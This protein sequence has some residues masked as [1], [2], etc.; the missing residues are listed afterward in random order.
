MNKERLL[1]L[2]DHLESGKL[3]HDRFDFGYIHREDSDQPTNT[4][5]CAMGE[6]KYCFSELRELRLPFLDYVSLYATDKVAK[7]QVIEAYRAEVADFETLLCEFFDLSDTELAHFFYPWVQF[8]GYESLGYKAT[9]EQVV[10]HIRLSVEKLELPS[11]ELREYVCEFPLT[12]MKDN[13]AS[14][15]LTL[16]RT[17]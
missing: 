9:K 6:V 3:G 10:A 7:N 15:V 17:S 14:S 2:A 8:E 5:G 11:L 12:D 1:K 4:C 16:R 13:L